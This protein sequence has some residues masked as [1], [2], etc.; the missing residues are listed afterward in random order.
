M[1][2]TE[3]RLSI[4]QSYKLVSVEYAGKYS[5][6]DL[7]SITWQCENCGNGIANIATVKGDTDGKESR[8]G[9]DCA[10][11]L[12]GIAP[13]AIAQAKKQM[14]KEAQFRKWI[15]EECVYW[16]LQETDGGKSQALMFEAKPRS[17][18]FPGEFEM[19][20]YAWRCNPDKYAAALPADK[21]RTLI[22]TRKTQPMP[23]IMPE[24]WKQYYA[25]A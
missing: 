16:I 4:A 14:R 3:G 17:W 19:P 21:F 18:D 15:R 2:A 12:T 9:L 11:V 20:R 24:Y 8:I 1:K 13:D 7:T 22:P 25:F 23:D 6:S 5:E 10:A